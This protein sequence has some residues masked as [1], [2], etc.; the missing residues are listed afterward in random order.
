MSRMIFVS[1][2]VDDLAKSR[3]FFTA[4]GFE[5]NDTFSDDHATS[6]VVSEQA[7]VMLLVRSFFAGSIQMNSHRW[8][9]RS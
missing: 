9:S 4:L 3:A 1:L 8:P 6:L 5:L 2:P 7:V